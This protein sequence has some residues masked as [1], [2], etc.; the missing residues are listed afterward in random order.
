MTGRLRGILITDP[1]WRKG[2]TRQVG[3]C[4]VP[5]HSEA[6]GVY[7]PADAGSARQG[8]DHDRM[9]HLFAAMRRHAGATALAVVAAV[10]ATG[11]QAITPPAAVTEQGQQISDLYNLVFVVAAI[12]FFLV[13]GLIVW[14]VIRYRRRPGQNALPAQTHGN[15]ALELVWTA[16]PLI[17]VVALFFASWG[18][19]QSVDARDESKAEVKVEVV[20]YQWQWKFGYPDDAIEIYGTADAPPQLVLPIGKRAQVTLVA[21]DVNHAFYVPQFLFQ[22]DAVPGH[23]NVFQFTPNKLGTFSGQCSHFCGLMHHAMVFSVK[24]VSDAD[25]AAWLVASKPAT[26]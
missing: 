14:S 18:V 16:I 23:V 19:L 11:C 20:A 1:R 9:Q 12:V 10:V 5:H 24:V 6:A 15:L 21:Q 3:R 8:E 7:A 17:T 26:P 22:R 4:Y 2:S 25:Y 13:E